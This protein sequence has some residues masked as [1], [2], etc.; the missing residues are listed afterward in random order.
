MGKCKICGVVCKPDFQGLC[1][2]HH[3]PIEFKIVAKM[4]EQKVAETTFDWRKH[5]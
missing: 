5:Y 4:P 2:F 3:K 1:A